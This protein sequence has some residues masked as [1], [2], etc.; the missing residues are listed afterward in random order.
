[1]LLSPC[2]P[3]EGSLASTGRG[4]L[5]VPAEPLNSLKYNQPL[6]LSSQLLGGGVKSYPAPPNLGTEP[7]PRREST[8][9]G[10]PA[11]CWER[12]PGC[13]RRGRPREGPHAQLQQRRP[14][15]PEPK[16]RRRPSLQGGKPGLQGT[17]MP[18]A[19]ATWAG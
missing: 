1:M 16:E 13:G 10:V 8:A 2:G 4:G 18:K 14:G 12:T 11:S 6:S 17:G 19:R 7:G 3:Q 15:Q 5:R 9:I